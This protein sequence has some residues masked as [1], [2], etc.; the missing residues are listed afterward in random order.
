MANSSYSITSGTTY[1]AKGGGVVG[2]VAA[3]R[4]LVA[5]INRPFKVNALGSYDHSGNP[6]TAYQWNGAINSTS[7][8]PPQITFTS[9]GQNSFSLQVTSA[10]GTHNI[11]RLI[12]VVPP[13][14]V[15]GGA[16]RNEQGGA[17]QN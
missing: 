10:D 3:I 6:I 1:T 4:S 12:D 16:L 13:F 8:T 5:V 9:L 14:M 17:I 11:T 2:P 15:N 7:A